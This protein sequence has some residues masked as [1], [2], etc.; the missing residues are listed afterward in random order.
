MNDDVIS[1]NWIQFEIYR[2]SF[3]PKQ[4]DT[5]LVLHSKLL[6]AAAGPYRGDNF[7]LVRVPN[8]FSL[9]ISDLECL[10]SLSFL[11]TMSRLYLKS[12]HITYSSYE[13]IEKIEF[14]IQQLNYIKKM[15]SRI[16]KYYNGSTISPLSLSRICPS[17]GVTISD[18]SSHTPSNMV[19]QSF[20]SAPL[21]FFWHF[22]TWTCLGCSRLHEM[23]ERSW[24]LKPAPS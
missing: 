4:S 7:L 11:F 10:H 21:F 13:G 15:T 23:A 16:S 5:G 17:P 3:L 6:P 2:G 8:I 24:L 19:L 12:G 22:S 9:L 18:V 1:Q 14:S 20:M